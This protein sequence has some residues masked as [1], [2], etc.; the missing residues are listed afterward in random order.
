MER[1]M[2]T[3]RHTATYI[4]THT[5]TWGKHRHSRKTHIKT[6]RD[7]ES[8]RHIHTCRQTEIHTVT[9]ADRTETVTQTNIHRDR[10]SLHTDGDMHIYIHTQMQIDT[11]R[12]THMQRTET[13][14]HTQKD[15]HRD[16]LT[17]TET[18]MQTYKH[19]N[20]HKDT[21]AHV[22]THWNTHTNEGCLMGSLWE[23]YVKP[24]KAAA[25]VNVLK[26]AREFGF[27]ATRVSSN[28]TMGGKLLS[29][30]GGWLTKC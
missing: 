3:H 19:K 10:D 21:N 29:Q 24:K 15:R 12:C 25:G 6:K 18:H 26:Q 8:Q 5:N 27:L 16:T 11:H 23:I 30:D 13:Q 2:E 22:K 17:Y 4:Q 28:G 20:T 14:R 7:T 9:Q 1:P